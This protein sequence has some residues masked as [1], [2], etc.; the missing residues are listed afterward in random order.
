MC[1][2]VKFTGDL[3]VLLRE[4]PEAVQIKEYLNAGGAFLI[5]PDQMPVKDEVEIFCYL[6]D[7]VHFFI[8]AGSEIKIFD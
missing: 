4:I 1:Y 8:V 3:E 6:F 7:A 5:E 2:R